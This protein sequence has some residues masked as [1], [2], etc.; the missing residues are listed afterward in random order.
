MAIIT[1]PLNGIEYSAEDAETYLCTRTSGVFSAD[2]NFAASITGDMTITVSPGIAW[3]QNTERAGKSVV[4]TSPVELQVPMADGT[5]PR[6]D[7]VVLRFDKAANKS[8]LAIKAGE[9]SSRPSAPELERTE[10]VYELGLYTI[11]VLAGATQIYE[12]HLTST[13]MDEDVCG[14]MRDGVTG[15]P[16]AQ[17]Q[18][19]VQALIDELRAVIDGVEGGSENMLKSYY[20]PDGTG[21]LVERGGTGAT[22]AEGAR[23]N[24]QAA[25]KEHSH[26]LESD[27]IN[28]VLGPSK[29]GTGK[30]TLAAALSALMYSATPKEITDFASGVSA[31]NIGS[32]D[33]KTVRIRKV[34]N[35]VFLEGYVKINDVT[36]NTQTLFNVPS[37]YAPTKTHVLFAPCSGTNVARI[38]VYATNGAVNLNWIYSFGGSKVTGAM[39]WV[40]VDTMW[41]I[42]GQPDPGP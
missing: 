15:I 1:Y 28:G 40:A 4:S 10:L 33:P 35:L 11:Y 14:L 22:T 21:I 6:I 34:G 3:I 13:M 25:A 31:T 37:G 8:S 32:S 39:S 24:L 16:T 17:L 7:R 18:S 42:G 23:E 27:E 36:G 12:A 2:D 30:T 38:N 20:D 29:G 9:P 5:R 26:D 41:V 19:Q